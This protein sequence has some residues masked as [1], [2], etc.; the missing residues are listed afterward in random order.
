MGIR[1]FKST[2][3]STKNA[4]CVTERPVP[5]SNGQSKLKQDLTDF[6][7]FWPK[8]SLIEFSKR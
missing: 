8:I 3:A 6:P 1:D 2:P 7:M 4:R 5:I